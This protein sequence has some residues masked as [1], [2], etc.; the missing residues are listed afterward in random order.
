MLLLIQFRETKDKEIGVL[1]KRVG[2]KVREVS[3]VRGR[4]QELE[5]EIKREEEEMIENQLEMEGGRE[6]DRETERGS[7]PSSSYY[8]SKTKNL[9]PSS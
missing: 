8:S 5:R 1:E 9:T 4:C 3:K 6:R 7:E 2:A